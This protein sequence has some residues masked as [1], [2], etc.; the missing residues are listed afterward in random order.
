MSLCL[1][2]A[3]GALIT[4]DGLGKVHMSTHESHQVSDFIGV[5]LARW[6]RAAWSVD[7][8]GRGITSCWSQS[9]P[10]PG[11]RLILVIGHFISFHR[12][13]PGRLAQLFSLGFTCHRAFAALLAAADLCFLVVPFQRAT[14]PLAW[15]LLGK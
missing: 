7:D 10:A 6:H 5:F 4:W 9:G 15:F 13:P 2:D 14:P 1:V 3:V 11:L 12:L 8:H